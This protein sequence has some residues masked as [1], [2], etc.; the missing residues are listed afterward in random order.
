MKKKVTDQI[1]ILDRCECG[2]AL[3]VRFR[4]E[5]A[6]VGVLAATPGSSGE[7]IELEPHGDN[8]SLFDVVPSDP[9]S[10]RTGPAQVATKSYRDSWDRI[11]GRYT[12]SA[13]AN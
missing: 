13:L 7:P 5:Q 3:A 1:L 8:P 12:S 2:D 6:E 4:G 10:H 11:W 9:S